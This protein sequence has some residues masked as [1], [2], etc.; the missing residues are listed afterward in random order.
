MQSQLK[1]GMMALHCCHLLVS[2]FL[3]GAHLFCPS[4][5]VWAPSLYVP[6]AKVS[7]MGPIWLADTICHV[8][9]GQC[10]SVPTGTCAHSTRNVAISWAVPEVQPLKVRAMT[11][12][13]YCPE[14]RQNEASQIHSYIL[15]FCYHWFWWVWGKV[16]SFKNK[17]MYKISGWDYTW[18]YTILE[19]E[20]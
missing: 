11:L 1:W 5:T 12:F 7:Q 15:N 3:K 17:Q 20:A 14:K 16:A 10:F 13:T 6:L 2:Q 4:C 19:L 18:I 8:Y 9:E